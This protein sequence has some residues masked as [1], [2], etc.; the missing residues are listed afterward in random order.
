M[1]G[2]KLHRFL[3]KIAP[4]S[5]FLMR[6]VLTAAVVI[7]TLGAP[8]LAYPQIVPC[9][10]LYLLDDTTRSG[11]YIASCQLTPSAGLQPKSVISN[12]T[13][14]VLT[15]HSTVF[16]STTSPGW[17]NTINS[18]TFSLFRCYE[19]DESSLIAKCLPSLQG[20][21]VGANPPVAP[22]WTLSF[23]SSL[24]PLGLSTTQ[25]QDNMK[26]N[27]EASEPPPIPDIR[28]VGSDGI[29]FG[30]I[31]NLSTGNGFLPTT[32]PSGVNPCE[33]ETSFECVT[34]RKIKDSGEFVPI[35]MSGQM[36]CPTP[37]PASPANCYVVS[38]TE[39]QFSITYYC[40]TPSI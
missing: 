8:R 16:L 20:L 10:S 27:T 6:Y 3:N 12:A 13:Q 21:S 2:L 7:T 14:I 17:N 28:C 33:S 18:P 34:S 40:P 35:T 32:I 24:D 23:N 5:K 29:F 9:S 39:S 25:T 15:S 31:A 11:Y 1:N 37:L 26:M 36:E 19:D 38:K 22:A 30:L 4:K